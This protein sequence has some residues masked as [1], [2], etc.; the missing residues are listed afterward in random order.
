MSEENIINPTEEIPVVEEQVVIEETSTA[1]TPIEKV[2]EEETTVADIP[3]EEVV[4]EE[5]VETLSVLEPTNS[6]AEETQVEIFEEEAKKV[7]KEEKLKV[8]PAPVVESDDNF[9]TNL[10]NDKKGVIS[11]ERAHI[12]DLYAAT[13][14]KVKEK[15]IIE[16]TIVSLDAKDVL[17]NIGYKSDG[18]IPYSEVKYSDG[19]FVGENIKIGDKIKV[20][21]VSLEDQNGRLSLSH[22]LART[23]EAWEKASEMC[24]NKEQFIGTIKSRTKGGMIVDVMGLDAFLPG[25][26]IDTKASKDFDAYVGQKIELLIIKINN[27]TKNIVVSHKAISEEEDEA[28][29][30]QFRESLEKGAIYKGAVKNITPYGVFVDLGNG[31]DGLI[32]LKDLS[33]KRISD[34]KDVVEVGQEIDVVILDFDESRKKIS[35]GVKQL[36]A[37]PWEALGEDI[38]E[39]VVVTGKVVKIEDYGAFVE[40]QPGIEGLIHVSEMTWSQH[41][42]SPKDFITVGEEIKAV[43]ISLDKEMQRM[44]LSIKQLTKDPWLD[45]EKNYKV[46][47]KHKGIVKNFTAF[48]IFVELEPGIDGLVHISDLSWTKKIKHPAEFTKVG[49]EI[50]TVVLDVNTETR[51]IKLGH[52]QVEEN[53]WETYESVYTKGSTHEATITAITDKSASILFNEGLE[54]SVALRNL[55]KEDGTIPVVGETLP[56]VVLDFNGDSQKIIVSHVNTYKPT[57]EEERK[58]EE[59]A[60]QDRNASIKDINKKVTKSTL[61]DLEDLQALKEQLEKSEKKSQKSA[62]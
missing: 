50:E 5:T 58:I 4:E 16:G 28:N 1:E 13:M 52:K 24:E 19:S 61:G 51:Q 17:I 55:K 32:V 37:A 6:I 7:A 33:W 25:S 53:P 59:K 54:T 44:S 38:K 40:I 10:E 26:Q 30:Q 43:I 36:S 23:L 47:S 56:F 15:E 27:E 57:E 2:V 8:K 20:M 31:V 3:V 14:N 45:I 18:I 49:A 41:V 39:G 9:W 46:G 34:P 42:R 21:V 35:L 60:E 62:E 48:G 12:E 29:K 11:A 22:K